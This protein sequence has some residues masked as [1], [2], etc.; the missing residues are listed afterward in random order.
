MLNKN[1]AEIIE[2]AMF[3]GNANSL[4]KQLTEGVVVY[5]QGRAKLRRW[6]DENKN[7]ICALAICAETLRPLTQP[8]VTS[9]AKKKK[10]KDPYA[11]IPFDDEI[12]M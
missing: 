4:A 2:V 5:I 8:L 7:G 1:D 3:K 9:R 11:P 10:I 12:P 6:E